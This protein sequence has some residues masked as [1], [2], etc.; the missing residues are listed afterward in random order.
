[1]QNRVRT[2]RKKPIAL[3]LITGKNKARCEGLLVGNG[4]SMEHMSKIGTVREALQL[5]TTKGKS[6]HASDC[7]NGSKSV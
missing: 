1:M 6:S 5:I 4:T 7:G 2:S 3:K